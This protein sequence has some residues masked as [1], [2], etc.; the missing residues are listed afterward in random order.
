MGID[1]VFLGLQTKQNY[2][3]DLLIVADTRPDT[4]FDTPFTFEQAQ[5]ATAIVN[6]V[7]NTYHKGI[8]P[9]AVPALFGFMKFI[10][11]QNILTHEAQSQISEIIQKATL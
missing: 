4:E 6:A 2:P 1:G 10:H 11:A 8:N 3:H 5:N 7:N 9:E